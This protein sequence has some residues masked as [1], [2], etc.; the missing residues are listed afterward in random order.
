MVN[1]AQALDGLSMIWI[2]PVVSSLPLT[3]IIVRRRDMT[4]D[5]LKEASHQSTWNPRG[6]SSDTMQTR[7]KTA[8]HGGPK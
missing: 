8:I 2:P 4:L 6:F 5:D 7:N 1:G 3:A